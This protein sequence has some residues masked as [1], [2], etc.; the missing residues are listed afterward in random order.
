V[1]LIPRPWQTPMTDF[2]LDVKRCSI[3]ASMGSGKTA[4]VLSAIEM[5]NLASFPV[6]PVLV[7]APKRVARDV[8]PFEKDKWDHLNHL[9]VSVILGDVKQ[10][11]RALYIQADVYTINYEN[12]PW[13]IE[14]CGDKW[15]FRFVVADESTRLKGFRLRA[16]TKRAAALA[17]IARKTQRWV[18]LTGTPS[19][20]GLQDLWGQCWFID[21][22]ERL[23]RTW[24]AFKD[25]WFSYNQY[26]FT[27][28]P[29]PLA[30]KQIPEALKD[31]T[32]TIDMKDWVDLKDP[33]YTP[34]WVNLP[35]DARA[36]YD[37]LEKYM[38]AQLAEDKEV[39]ALNAAARS[40][41]CLQ[42]AAGAV[43]YEDGEW[44]PVHDAKLDAL[45]SVIEELAG[46][47]LVVFY[48]WKH[49][50]IRIQQRFPRARTLETKQDENDWNAGKIPLL[51]LHPQSA[52]HG[53]NLQY[54]G[55]HMVFF[56]D[57]WNLEYRMQ[58]IERLGP[59][60][61][62]QAGLDRLVYIYA[63]LARGTVDELVAKRHIQKTETQTLLLNA[64]KK[65][66]AT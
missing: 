25:R 37:E 4:A 7:I 50:I 24:T 54:G 60:R 61:Q 44:M 62:M 48:W 43:Y 45:E 34:I 12:I 6:F 65:R 1:K 5:L 49:D 19:P 27:T 39:S 59:V 47:S 26:T 64:M 58:A 3:W 22:G 29:R 8:W 46:A 55:H 33:V 14:E 42:L 9:R 31:V 30:Q 63:I 16:G 41:K 18:N 17:Q 11:R 56:S 52:G 23:G 2:I 38:F 57:W 28:T 36:T 35:A 40:I 10:R 13:L 53:L 51:L 21:C 66:R 15:P 20:N 32:L